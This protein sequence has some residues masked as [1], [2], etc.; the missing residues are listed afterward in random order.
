MHAAFVVWPLAD[1]PLRDGAICLCVSGGGYVFVQD[2][3]EMLGHVFV[4]VFLIEDLMGN[5]AVDIRNN[6]VRTAC[7]VV[8]LVRVLLPPLTTVITNV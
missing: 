1:R 3:I 7:G 6:A 2:A 4:V 8:S 5:L